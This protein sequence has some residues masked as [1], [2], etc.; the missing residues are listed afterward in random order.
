[1]NL[2][3]LRADLAYDTETGVFTYVRSPSFRPFNGRVAGSKMTHGYIEIC[4]QG[5]RYTAHRLAWFYVHGVWPKGTIDHVNGNRADNRLSNLR[6]VPQRV[7][8]GN[9]SKHRSGKLVGTEFV[10]DK[11]PWRARMK[12]NGKSILIGRFQTEAEAHEAYL[13]ARQEWEG[14][15]CK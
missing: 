6:D 12:V 1:M 3:E 14:V 9:S 5:K 10:G 11:N 7:N 8:A 15:L 2:E 4:V 13:F